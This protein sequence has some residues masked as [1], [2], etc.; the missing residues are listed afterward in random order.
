MSEL[1]RYRWVLEALIFPLIVYGGLIMLSPSPF[2]DVI[3]E[4]FHITEVQ[5]GLIIGVF[6]MAAV[7]FPLIA[8]IV[9]DSIG[10]KKT[11]LVAAGLQAAFGYLCAI[12]PNYHSLLAFR[13]LLGMG[14][15]FTMPAASPIVMTWFSAREY[16][17]VN[18]LNVVGIMVGITICYLLTP[19]FPD[20]RT[21]TLAYST[22]ALLVALLWLFL[23]KEP[24]AEIRK[25]EP[26]VSRLAVIKSKISKVVHIKDIL[27]LCLAQFVAMGFIIGM[28]TWLPKYFMEAYQLS[29]ATAAGI[30]GALSLGLV[31]SLP[32][33]GVLSDKIG[34]RTPFLKIAGV[35]GAAAL[36]LMITLPPP[37]SY[38][39]AFLGGFTIL[40]WGFG[41]LAIPM[42]HPE[43]DFTLISYAVSVI[44]M[45]GNIGAVVSPVL[46]AAVSSTVSMYAAMLMCALLQVVVT[47]VGFLLRE[48][49]WR[50]L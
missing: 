14:M 6:A 11:F 49:G 47:I 17:K 15:S 29:R 35:S 38:L 24:L 18:S 42:E 39:F 40:I 30:T 12:A 41:G 9:V 5:A 3:A 31:F 50:A 33:G 16:G 1:P 7:I 37:L 43:M 36:A 27:L 4:E 23:G 28:N 26:G 19:R 8:S 44:L 21:A 25:F 10:A 22:L 2:L 20:W 32:V 46:I 34:L 45:A 13:F 48:T